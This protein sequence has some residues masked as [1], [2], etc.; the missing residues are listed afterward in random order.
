MCLLC[1]RSQSRGRPRQDPA[2]NP[3]GSQMSASHTA[4]WDNASVPPVR[5]LRCR[6]LVHVCKLNLFSDLVRAKCPT[7]RWIT[8]R[9]SKVVQKCGDQHAGKIKHSVECRKPKPDPVTAIISLEVVRTQ[10]AQPELRSAVLN[11]HAPRKRRNLFVRPLR[12]TTRAHAHLRF[13]LLPTTR[14]RSTS[15][16]HNA[17]AE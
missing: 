13:P 2:L 1:I 12:L 15:C 4:A 5:G 7:G 3:V 6:A 10:Q 8:T 16:S 9:S 11:K 17:E 14:S